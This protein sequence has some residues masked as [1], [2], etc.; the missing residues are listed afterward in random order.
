V[1]PLLGAEPYFGQGQQIGVLLQSTASK[2]SR[3][4]PTE[5]ARH[6]SSRIVFLGLHEPQS[7]GNSALPSSE[8]TDPDSAMPKLKGTPYFAMDV[9]DLDLPPQQVQEILTL[10]IGQ[11]QV[12]S[13]SE[14]RALMSSMDQFSAAVFASAR[15]LVDWNSRNKVSQTKIAWALQADSSI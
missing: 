8:F 11:G 4:S 9:T 5:T 7:D 2:D 10:A 12:P 14:P 1:K 6:L 13:W 3:H 15:S